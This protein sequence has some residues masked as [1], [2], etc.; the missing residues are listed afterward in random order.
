[1]KVIGVLTF[2]F[3]ASA[4][5]GCNNNSNDE[6]EY[7]STPS[8]TST[9]TAPLPDSAN[10]TG[11]I[12]VPDVVKN[13][14]ASA[15]VTTAQLNPPHGQPG[16]RCDIA[17]GKPLNSKPA[18]STAVTSPLPAA[19]APKLPPV[20][21]TP[22]ATTG[23]N[24]PHGQPGHRCDIAVGKPLNSAP[25]TAAQNSNVASPL[26]TLPSTSA[27]PAVTTAPGMNPPHGQPGHR[28]DIAVGK[29]LNSKPLTP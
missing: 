12:T 23:L 1:M 22:L 10:R 4:I 3:M 5:V 26:P 8:N 14:A 6:D 2:F 9:I 21:T 20:F 17:V 19:N 27:A 7:E 29:P 18:A 24:P 16:H 11:A 28:C 15:A 13:P 25:A